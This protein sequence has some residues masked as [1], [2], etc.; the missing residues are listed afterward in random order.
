MLHAQV[1][2]ARGVEQH[3]RSTPCRVDDF[4]GKGYQYWAL[5]HV[6]KR[7]QVHGDP[8]AWYPGNL[9]G[10]N[11]RKTGAK[12]ALLVTVPPGGEPVV[13][14]RPLAPV[15]WETRPTA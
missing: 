5:G 14:F 13:E 4:A 7:Q 11:F 10:R 9:Q 12:G 2:T 15:R 3:D 1:D 6:H 8:V